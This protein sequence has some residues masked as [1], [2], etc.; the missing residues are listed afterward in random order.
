MGLDQ[1]RGTTS[2]HPSS[3]EPFSHSFFCSPPNSFE[4]VK[5]RCD[6]GIFPSS[7]SRFLFETQARFSVLLGGQLPDLCDFILIP[8]AVFPAPP[9]HSGFEI[10]GNRFHTSSWAHQL[11]TSWFFFFFSSTQSLDI[12]KNESG[13]QSLSRPCSPHS[14]TPNFTLLHTLTH[15]PPLPP[16]PSF[17]DPYVLCPREWNFLV[18]SHHSWSFHAKSHT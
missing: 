12:L 9:L 8:P 2:A 10:V 5:P 3:L 7:S 4:A 13:C 14:P 11:R 1:D 15:P 6:L 18:T 16:H 17:S